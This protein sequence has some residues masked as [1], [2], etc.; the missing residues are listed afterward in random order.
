MTYI[1]FRREMY[2]QVVSNFITSQTMQIIY[3]PTQL[4]DFL[5]LAMRNHM[6][7]LIK[8][9]HCQRHLLSPHC[10]FST[11][12][13]FVVPHEFT[14]DQP[15]LGY[16]ETRG[17]WVTGSCYPARATSGVFRHLRRETCWG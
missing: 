7:K 15:L 6:S 17:V 4:I 1:V 8:K 12:H 11:K 5:M 2:A 14:G 13:S 16:S 10:I 3:L 9:S